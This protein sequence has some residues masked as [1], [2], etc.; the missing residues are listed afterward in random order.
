MKPKRYFR[1]PIVFS[2]SI[3][4]GAPVVLGFAIFISGTGLS[5]GGSFKG[6]AS[7]SP[8]APV[9]GTPASTGGTTPAAA[10]AIRTNAL[11]TVSRRNQAVGAALALQN[12]AKAAAAAQNAGQNP[13]NPSQ[14]LPDVPNGL[15]TGGLQVAPGV[16][17]NPNLWQGAELP[18]QAIADGQTNVTVRQTAQQ[19]LLQWQTFN[20]GKDTTLTFDQSAAGGNAAQWIAFNKINDPSANPTQIL[21]KIQAQGQVYI[22]NGNGIIFGGSSQV[23]V[24][25]L[26][27]SSL[28]INDN[29]VAR[30]LLNNPDAQFLFS[31]IAIPAGANGTP[32]FTPE[33]PPTATGR[34]G[35]V[36]VQAG[37]QIT[38]P[39]TAAKVGGRVMLAGPNVT[40]SGTISTADG[41]TILAA[42]MQVGINSHSSADPSLRGLDIFIGQVGTAG[43]ATNNGII[44][45]PRG[46]IVMAGKAVNQ[47]GL[48]QS[49]T[50]VS[51][52]GR[53][54]L[55]AHYDAISNLSYDPSSSIS[56]TPFLNRNSGTVTLGEASLIE[57]LPELDSKETTVGS[58]LALRSQI[59][60][61][62]KSVYLGKGSL[63]YAPNAIVN[64]TAGEWNYLGGSF[65]SSTF[66][67]TG[68]QVYLDE[69]A[70][71]DVSGS[72]GVVVPVSQNIV[73]IDLR[74]AELADSPLQ[75]DGVLRN[76]TIYVD[77]RDAGVYQQEMWI[78]TPLADVSGYANLIQKTVGELT[79]AGG[80]VNIKAGA[81]V[82][83]QTGSNINVSGGS[84]FYE[85]GP[86]RTTML[87]TNGRL[88][89]IRD[90]RPDV[91]YDGI[92][93]GA[94]T[95]T[96][97]KW[98]TSDTY[99]N[100]HAPGAVRYEA[101]FTHGAA[102]GA[103]SITAPS[104]ALDGA[105][106]G[107]TITGEKQQSTPPTASSLTLSFVGQDRSYASL[108]TYSPFSPDV[109]F[110]TTPTQTAADTFA[111]D[112]AGN[113]LALRADRANDV[114]LSASLLSESGFGKFTLHNPDG[115]ITVPTGVK[116]EAK[117][118]GSM[119][120]T[121]SNIQI[122][123]SV[124]AAGGEL[125]FKANQVS[126]TALN[127]IANTSSPTLP[128]VS[129]DRGNFVLGANG[130]IST[131]GQRVNQ[132]TAS[133][134]E[135][136]TTNAGSIS[137]A[138][139]STVLSVGGLID[140]SGGAIRD[141]VGN[142]SYGDAGSI[143]LSGGRDNTISAVLGGNLSLGA[144]LAGYA[145]VGADSGSLALT[146]PAFQIGGISSHDGAVNLDPAF[147]NNGGFSNITLTG[148]GINDSGV[149]FPGILISEN[150]QIR[151]QVS[152]VRAE[153]NETGELQYVEYLSEEGL[154][155]TSS[156]SFR[157]TGAENP[158]QGTIIVRGDVVMEKGSRIETDAR[159][160]VSFEGETVAIHGTVITPGGTIEVD[161]SN[162][163]P[164]DNA[165]PTN[166]LPTTWI[167]SEAML[168]T[169]GK[170]VLVSN[171]Y[172]LRQGLVLSGGSISISGNI[173]AETGAILDVSGTSGVLDLATGYGSLTPTSPTSSGT[174]R[175]VPVTIETNGGSI[176]LAGGEM[177]YSNAT[178]IGKSG[179]T[180][181]TGGSLSV[182][183]GKFTPTGVAVNSAEI[184]LIVRQNG[185]NLPSDLTG[186]GIGTI[187]R[188]AN[189]N[190]LNGIGNFSVDSYS[191]G[192]FGSL[193]LGGNVRFDGDV[194]ITAP[195][196]LD[197]A[198]G[199]VI[200]A[201]GNVI[202]EAGYISLGQAF[203]PPALDDEPVVPFTQTNIQG[204]TS[205]YTFA[206]T[207]GT[208]SLS[209]KADLID[210]G[211][212]S[213][214]GIGSVNFNASQGDIRGNGTLSTAASLLFHA[215]QI[216]PTTYGDFSIF[217]YGGKSVTI[218]AG[219]T[220]N[221]PLSAGG[222]LSIF[223][224]EIY[225]SGTLRAP[226]G[227][228][229]LGYD[230]VT[231]S[232]PVNALAGTTLAAPVTSQLTLA[233]GSVT[234]VSAIDPITGKPV[235][236]PYGIS[237]DGD[238][239]IDPAGNDITVGGV[240]GKS[241]SLSAT[242]LTSE[243]NSTIDISGGG[244][245]YAYRWIEGNGGSVDILNSSDSFAIIP[246][247][248]FDYAPYAPFN[249]STSAT[250]LGGNTG[251]TNA[252]LKPGDQITI[253]GSNGLPAGT[254]TLLPARYALLPGAFLVT[255]TTGTPAGS[256]AQPDGSSIV[257]GYIA[258]N[259]DASRTGITRISNF[260]IAS[261]TIVR[262]RAQYQDLLANT[263]LSQ[264]AIARE[265]AVPR[266]PQDAG[267]LSFTASTSMSLLGDVSSVVSSGAR[268]SSIDINS[269][270]DI[271]INATGTGGSPG[272]LVLSS[273][274]LNRFGAESLLIGGLRQFGTEGASVTTSTGSL[275]LDNAGAALIGSD[276]ILVAKENLNLE[277]D[278]EIVS[279][280][281]TRSLDH[282]IFG[283]TGTSG[284]GDGTLVRVSG[285]LSATVERRGVSSSN[286]PTLTL[287]AGSTFT[288]ASVILDSTYAT[289]LDP[290]AVLSAESV[291][292]SSGSIIIEGENAGIIPTTDSLV[293]SG[294]ALASL[295]QSASRLSLVSYGN[296]DVYGTGQ[297]GS[298]NFAELS[299][300]ASSI[301]GFNLNGGTFTFA[302]GNLNLSG[303]QAS[304]APST[305]SVDGTLV[306]DAKQ[307]TLG[308]NNLAIDR[309][310]NVILSAENRL[311]TSGTGTFH[312]HSDLEIRT[313]LVTGA[314]QAKYE[315]SSSGNLS[316]ERP[317]ITGSPTA[318][319]LG[320]QLT[321]KAESLEINSDI[322]LPSG[323]LTLH[324]TSGDLLIG[325]TGLTR[326][327][328]SGTEQVFTDVT[329]YSSGG[330]V[331]LIADQGSIELA[332]AATVD[333]SAHV[334][335]GNAG[336]LNIET[337]NGSLDLTGSIVASA[338]TGY[339]RGS[340]TLDVSSMPGGSLAALDNT[341]NNGFFT[342]SRDYRVRQGDVLIDGA[343]L[344]KTYRVATDHGDI[345]V[346]GSIDASGQTGG[347]IDLKSNG[348]LTL[349]T[350]SSLT[351]AATQFD[352]AGKGGSVTLEA[353]TQNNGVID[354]TATLDLQ[355]GSTINLSVA[356]NDST[357]AR[358]GKFTGTLH[359]RAPR[360]AN[361]A[362][363]QIQAIGSTITGASHILVEG[364]K[365]YDLT[366]TNGN[367]TTT[368]QNQIK[369]DATAYLG[370]AGTTTAGY[371]AMNNRLTSLQ[372]GLDLILA[373]GVEI[374]NRN[375][376]LSLGTSNSTSTADWNLSS[377]R[378]GP[379]GAAGVLTLR[380]SQ[381]LTFYNA[382]SDGFA[383]GT[384]LWL[385]PLMANNPLLQANAQSWSY[386][387][388]AG[389]DLSA[390]S[391]REVLSEE[392]VTSG[393]G[394][395][396]L[397]KNL[398]S[399]TATGGSAA[400]TSSLV[401]ANYQV[402]RTGSGN[403]DINTTDSIRLLNTF[404]T[405]YT[406]GTQV[407]APTTVLT[408][409]D[410]VVPILNRTVT[411]GNLG[412]AQ[413]TYAAQ[414]SMA[415][416]NVTL[417]SGKNI[418]RK[419]RNNSGLIDDSSRQ[420]PTNW[421]YRRGLVGPDGN[422]GSIRIG[423]GL[424]ATTDTSAST[425]WWVDFSNF[426]QGI[427]ALGG[428]NIN[429]TASNDINNIDAVIPTNARAA[430][431]TPSEASFIELGGGDLSVKSGNDIS[432]GVYYVE[433][434]HGSLDAGGAITTNSTR[435]PSYGLVANLN[436]PAAT[437]LD[438]KTWLPTTLFVGKSNFDITAAGDILLGPIANAF[439]LPQGL[440]NRFWYKTYFSTYS[441][442]SGVSASSLG[443]DI[444]FR[445]SVTLPNQNRS[446]S[447]LLA[448]I[449]TQLLYTGTSSSTSWLQPWLR[450]SE[451]SITPFA[452]VLTLGA[453]NLF[454]TAL[455]GDLNLAGDYTL[456]PSETGQLEL[457]AA[458]S[459]NAL[460]ATGISNTLVPGRQVQTWKAANF[461][462]S[463][464]D[465]SSIP[466]IFRPF[467]NFVMT[468]SLAT[469]N[470]STIQNF[471]S[472]LASL[473]T[474]SGSFSGAN[475]ALQTKQ[476][477]HTAGLLHKDD[478]EPVRVYA[479]DGS[480]SGLTLF[481]PKA[482]RISASQD[483]TDI[484][485]YLQNLNPTDLS[486]ISAGRDIIAYNASSPSRN[487]A[488]SSGNAIESGGVPA[489]GD[490][491]ISG[492]GTLQVLA[493][494]NLD[495][496]IGANNSDGTGVGITSIGNLRNPY[497]PS[498]GADL[499][500]SAGLGPAVSLGDSALNWPAF[501]DQY[502]LT[503]KGTKYLEQIAPGI[504]FEALSEADQ[505][506][507][508]LEIF[509][510]VLRDT[511]RDF[512]DPDS[513][514]FRNYETGMAA[515]Q[516]L[517]GEDIEW[518]GEINTQ[519]RDIRTRN[520]GDISI[521]APGG[522]L[523]MAS[524]TLGNPLAPPGIITEAGGN[525]SIFADQSVNIGI[526][527]IFTLR[528]GNAILWSTNGDIAAGSSSRT[529]QSAPPTRVII[530]PQSASVQTDLA[531]LAT[532]GGIGVLAT[533]QG[534]DAGD[535][536]LI[537]PTG[538]IDAGDAGIR[539]TG[540]INLAAVQV[541]NSG[542]IS[543]GGASS[544]VPSATVSTPSIGSVTSASNA[545]AAAN[546]ATTQP[547]Q[548][549]ENST[550]PELESVN[551]LYTVE[552]IGYGGESSE[553][554][555]EED[556]EKDKDA[557]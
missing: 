363:V 132:I 249:P 478:D 516:T 44:T 18:T 488:I 295:Q 348:S 396:E 317:S 86:V 116:L 353:G 341:L 324:A 90:A 171:P 467:T 434:G 534:V 131:A 496:G 552:V 370:A 199:G 9:P 272:N 117:T 359:L 198:K 509:Y 224:S 213:L 146:A 94:V 61:A 499:F 134:S 316:L 550:T 436:N 525:I 378:F 16:G 251:Y 50:S 158:Y 30:G 65:P 367:I 537:A 258:N 482:A 161:G 286:I 459:I 355:T 139:Y 45:A 10:E 409:G 423:T 323:Q 557:Q 109:T 242:A 466:S 542:N 203:R 518:D 91:V 202:L 238:S 217:A 301:R 308:Q 221:L 343:A 183:S 414:Y 172:N 156:L 126:L 169:A 89:D 240:P 2:R 290:S 41:Q 472:S 513:P 462:L 529:I 252:T 443:G 397:G 237:S 25:T 178:L 372:T 349:E 556:K 8:A 446:Q 120:F 416:G 47:L 267:Y 473:F 424:G 12:A 54:D 344:S 362:D 214:Q 60:L 281:I 200:Q 442:D 229:R 322:S 418:E 484:S 524:T 77:I 13:N 477:R 130:L 231:G 48:L 35:D 113:P 125:N 11:E 208:G 320:S 173:V 14:T 381:N 20:V 115:N 151:P 403:I 505:T 554:E 405:I 311:I 407:V 412:S 225:Q 70:W 486:I 447:T 421:L 111:V 457:L 475:A 545:S 474:E 137:I 51:L 278:S 216:Y 527:R 83:M 546:A 170:T 543:A 239:W 325:N 168:S 145:G 374:I 162:Q 76:E 233:S 92:Y 366:G 102:G 356:A 40:N 485:F 420:L 42:G 508:A 337:P 369:A 74:G 201:N 279:T 236:I 494:R 66:V 196:S 528:G 155:A 458:G 78:G 72:S 84:I 288:G 351:V 468:G 303:N 189:G 215:G 108:P 491:Q 259:L 167:G 340:F 188:D 62:G 282:L 154:R 319:G 230:G 444:T 140:V 430:S 364:T 73:A 27:A 419:T 497:L 87:I 464:A 142:I 411:Q 19:A 533:V 85:G 551:S 194:S 150:T 393:T 549:P 269:P 383:G 521:F 124:I 39:T 519:G 182:S 190:A 184:N 28:P 93:G 284:S 185:S 205:A 517:L 79:V 347:T 289:H 431:G 123:G 255:P 312:S 490:I 261:T 437:T 438:S 522:G 392:Q 52:N 540:N 328:A 342:H 227:S 63:I 399:A 326:I 31:G 426:F 440:N 427:G 502:V 232:A 262:T 373:P 68:G 435:S 22:M 143:S 428:G 270:V 493:G 23:N 283:T 510:L 555:D 152:S 273:E 58:E 504:D 386:R 127:V 246:G 498:A 212:L 388:S 147:F 277:E 264:A 24:H 506:R 193:A 100:P 547:E 339:T 553:E 432:G 361:N 453:P 163:F 539:V 180:S 454:L 296:L 523:T 268:G 479:K 395:L 157:A 390:S 291:S 234:S 36:I 512:N 274:L 174:P 480:I 32:A 298:R 243:E 365:L 175:T 318:G 250:N 49:T 315:I 425:T 29:L 360:T 244:D 105:F 487:Q 241:I 166:P 292:L 507:L 138:G 67:Q 141:G 441:A 33:P 299:L 5:D 206:P 406:A 417:N 297:I 489:A 481:T 265:F 21:G 81:S 210:I 220:R 548:Q 228:I 439:L 69:D 98:G 535:V 43:T 99:Y 511:G 531:G 413:Q 254:Y 470:S 334:R 118:G 476:A 207:S 218:Q 327:N 544:G 135:S 358:L 95:F 176:S 422:Y 187:L 197:I 53:I 112:A 402:I 331:N 280:P 346:T 450:L 209:L 376:S 287:S 129:S 253:A 354:T 469:A 165:A 148:I 463:D 357:S 429:L 333:V 329:R 500:V 211:N 177:L 56:G 80:T 276:I 307:F 501:I 503:E 164:S 271:V 1:N 530:D 391:F 375:G 260:E 275:T 191:S 536:D 483:I 222:S 460:Q 384:N 380:A 515:I 335:G 119:T 107:H 159:G 526:G 371:T 88:V 449:E 192:G 17:T 309:F 314:Q 401:A 46:S 38:S 445:N 382:L 144:T 160:S 3:S 257:S 448:W 304:I 245:L 97:D 385:S 294:D 394:L 285:S 263:T 306:F 75:R 377:F 82:V 121:G 379:K 293:L 300:Q 223:A 248:G 59:N 149:N 310:E 532:G 492:P 452:S 26:A 332:S 495:L 6:F 266:L 404:A 186:Q 101:S 55:L 368:I 538:T 153:V 461:N 114:H 103:L 313:P 136:Y 338:S 408:E 451:T 352:N 336:N 345:T 219:T 122:D 64:L 410:F 471:L 520:G 110:L 541:V 456:S 302:A 387:L 34:Y 321:L 256:V 305:G 7:G 96:N 400:Q 433:R 15:G 106:T 4:Y 181:A 514:G 235:I 247:Y 204:V 455:S 133:S 104:M 389:A 415:G 195:G 350:G 37:A 128:G 179:G 398:G 226:I 71:I 57:I 465:P 330:T